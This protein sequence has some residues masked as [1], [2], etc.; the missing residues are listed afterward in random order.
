M[1]TEGQLS[2]AFPA[3]SGVL[4]QVVGDV[5]PL[6][7]GN[8]AVTFDGRVIGQ[9]SDDLTAREGLATFQRMGLCV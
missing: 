4:P 6:P 7:N 5:M 1:R 2:L 9:W 8:V 3:I